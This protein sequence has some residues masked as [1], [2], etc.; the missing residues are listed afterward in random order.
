MNFVMCSVYDKVAGQ[1]GRPFCAFSE[2]AAVRSFAS[3]V[4]RPD[5]MSM[6]WNN[7]DDFRLFLIAHFSDETGELVPTSQHHLLVDGS[8]VARRTDTVSAANGVGNRA[9]SVPLEEVDH[10]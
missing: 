8:V 1:F 10:G 6:L 9:A 3:E 4:N 2:A 7:P 5:D